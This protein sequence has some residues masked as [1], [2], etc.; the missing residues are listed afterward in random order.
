SSCRFNFFMVFLIPNSRYQILH[1]A[2][3]GDS[4]NSPEVIDA[5]GVEK[6]H[7]PPFG[8]WRKCSH[9]YES[10]ALGNKRFPGVFFYVE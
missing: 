7:L 4:H 1:V 9:E 3:Y 10:C 6:R 5:V 2:I 8:L